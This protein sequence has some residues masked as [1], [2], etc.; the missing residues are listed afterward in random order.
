[1]TRFTMLSV[2]CLC[3]IAASGFKFS[4][5]GNQLLFSRALPGPGPAVAPA[6]DATVAPCCLDSVRFRRACAL[7][8]VAFPK[9]ESSPSSSGVPSLVNRPLDSVVSIVWHFSKEAPDCCAKIWRGANCAASSCKC[10]N[11]I[12]IDWNCNVRRSSIPVCS[13]RTSSSTACNAQSTCCAVCSRK[14]LVSCTSIAKLISSAPPPAVAQLGQA[15][16]MR[17]IDLPQ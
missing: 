13:A 4:D 8:S 1:M 16:P 5:V 3:F 2:E 14:T 7:R 12:C 15:A 9:A 6:G 11:L 17:C 10:C